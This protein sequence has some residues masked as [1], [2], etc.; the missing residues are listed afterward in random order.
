MEVT[1]GL[2]DTDLS[3]EGRKRRERP[4]V[5]W[6]RKVKRNVT[7][8]SNISIGSKLVRMAQGN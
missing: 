8:E 2:S 7:E 4:E 3:L 5:K 6:E 1:D